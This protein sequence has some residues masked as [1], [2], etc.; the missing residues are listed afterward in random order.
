MNTIEIL[1]EP[2]DRNIYNQAAYHPMQSFEWGDARIETGISIVRIGEFENDVLHNVFQMSI[3][4]IPYTSFKIGYIPRSVWPSQK[5]LEFVKDYGKTHNLIFVKFEPYVEKETKIEMH[6]HLKNSPHPLFP[7]WT[8]ILDLTPSEEDLLKNCKSKTR[9]NI[10]LAERKGVTV[11]EESN[12]KGF[13]TFIKLYFDTT[14]RQQYYGHSETYHRIIWNHLKHSM[15]HILIA[16]YQ[17]V[18]LSAYELFHFHDRLYY[19]YGGSSEKHRD[20]MASNL[21]MWEAIRLGKK[22]N[23]TSF[24]MWGSLPADYDPADP[25][26][27][28]TRFKEGYGTHFVQYKGSYDL[29]ISDSL[30]QIYNTSHHLRNMY[31]KLRASFK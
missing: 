12:E 16:Y 15:A 6:H 5:L 24:D 2:F 8:Q 18:P 31:L 14:K 21:L 27:G 29:V 20:L 28:F 1:P 11:R 26:S 10:R 7:E 19:P 25:W 13:N 3:H 4:Q 22:M 9:Y 23:V 30:Y 17:D